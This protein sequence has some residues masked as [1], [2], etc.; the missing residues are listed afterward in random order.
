MIELSRHIEILLLDNDCVIVP[1]LGGFMAHHVEAR[2]DEEDSLFLPPL[3]TLGFNPQLRLNDS[4]L[5]QSYV[6]A[7]DISYPEAVRRIE[8]EVNEVKQRL[9]NEGKYELND[10]GVLSF[11][12]E[13]KLSFEPCEAGILTPS[14]YGLSSYGFKR[15]SMEQSVAATEEKSTVEKAVDTQG[16]FSEKTYA[17][18][19]TVENTEDD[20]EEGTIR[21]KISWIRNAVAMA[22]AVIAFFLITTPVTNSKVQSIATSDMN[23]NAILKLAHK[24][25]N[26]GEMNISSDNLRR[27]IDERDTLMS[28][29]SQ[30]NIRLVDTKRNSDRESI[31][32]V[33]YCIVMAS[34]VARRGAEALVKELRSEGYDTASVYEHKGVVRVVYGSYKTENEA[35]SR[36][37][38]LRDDERFEQSWIYKKR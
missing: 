7:Y 38:Q 31:A 15:R 18:T 19:P 32:H 5:A 30:A 37:R 1:G 4:L 27:S 23:V 14:L 22:A 29:T 26:K 24:E 11:T 8:D 9:D 13:G 2:Y 20:E 36:L 17:L 35:K 6:E 25:M 28:D 16:I 21:I 34:H 33:A 12:E 3:R 10:I